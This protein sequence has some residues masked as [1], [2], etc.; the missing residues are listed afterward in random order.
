MDH[1]LY[2]TKIL[3]VILPEDAM[4]VESEDNI[5]NNLIKDEENKSP[6]QLN[7]KENI[8]QNQCKNYDDKIII[9]YKKMNHIFIV[10]DIGETDFKKL[11]ETKPPI[12][13]E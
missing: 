1:N 6:T 10:M 12:S 11:M 9:D 5:I 2:T 4:E 8:N 7:E 3:D 13:I